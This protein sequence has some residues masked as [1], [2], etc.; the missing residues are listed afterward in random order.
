MPHS[1]SA[2]KRIRQGEKR[3]E[4]NRTIKSRIRT[5]RRAFLKAIEAA[6]VPAAKEKLKAA[7]VLIHRAANS[8][9]IHRNMAARVIGRM[10]LR[11]NAVEKA[12]AAAK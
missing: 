8:G 9:P 12:G 3:H 11:L 2:K 1:L 4:R 6:D 10:Q 5:A 7:A